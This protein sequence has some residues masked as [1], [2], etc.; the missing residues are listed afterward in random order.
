[1]DFLTLERKQILLVFGETL[2]WIAVVKN[3][4]TESN[5]FGQSRLKINKSGIKWMTQFC[6]LNRIPF[7]KCPQKRYWV[8][9]HIFFKGHH[10]RFSV[11]HWLWDRCDFTGNSILLIF[12]ANSNRLIGCD[13]SDKMI[14]FARRH[15]YDS[16]VAYQEL[17][18]G[19]Q[20]ETVHWC[21]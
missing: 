20:M 1:M 7:K 2:Y 3:T 4:A 16:N 18:I 6:T 5:K 13:I 10:T 9:F 17:D 12:P 21:S 8:S 15:N 11:G 19:G 14:E